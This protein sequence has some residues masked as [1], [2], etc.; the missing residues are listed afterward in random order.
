M[1]ILQFFFC[2]KRLVFGPDVRNLVFT[3]ILIIAPAVGFCA[4]VGRQLMKDF[5]HHWGNAIMV[6]AV[7]HTFVVSIIF[8]PTIHF[9]EYQNALNIWDI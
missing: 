6:V 7:V 1:L 5:P 2:G 3:L 9:W 8:L 4:S